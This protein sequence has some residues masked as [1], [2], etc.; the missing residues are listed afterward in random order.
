MVESSAFSN[1]D[2][3]HQRSVEERRGKG[4]GEGVEGEREEEEDKGLK[5][6]TRLTRDKQTD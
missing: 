3:V 2:S 5:D 4:E 6:A 1:T